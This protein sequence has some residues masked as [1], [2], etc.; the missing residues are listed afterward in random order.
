MQNIYKNNPITSLNLSNIYVLPINNNNKTYVYKCGGN[1]V[2]N[3][4][5][6][7]TSFCGTETEA[8]RLAE[9]LNKYNYSR[10]YTYSFTTRG[11]PELDVGDIVYQDDDYEENMLVQIVEHT[12]T[13]S[14]GSLKSEITTMHLS[15]EE[16]E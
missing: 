8:K 6:W 14:G 4:V 10:P 12:L 13:F 3:N 15:D 1:D 7:E 16:L 9:Y 2:N 11:F 5:T